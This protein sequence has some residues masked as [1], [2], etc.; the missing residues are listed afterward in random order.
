MGGVDEPGGQ[1]TPDA[2]DHGRPLLRRPLLEGQE[3]DVED[4]VINHDRILAASAD[5]PAE[6]PSPMTIPG[7]LFTTDLNPYC[8]SSAAWDSWSKPCAP[9]PYDFPISSPIFL[10]D[11]DARDVAPSIDFCARFA[12]ASAFAIPASNGLVSA[13]IANE[14]PPRF[15]WSLIAQYPWTFRQFA[16]YHAGSS[17]PR[18]GIGLGFLPP[19]K[20]LLICSN[21]IWSMVSKSQ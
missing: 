11:A 3:I 18:T 2:V 17:E 19:V 7:T 4:R 16:L 10:A 15:C 13:V 1:A 8:K 9:R 6:P 5:R 12:V 20:A 14:A 21:D